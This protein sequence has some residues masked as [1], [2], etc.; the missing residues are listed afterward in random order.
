MFCEE[1]EE[2]FLIIENVLVACCMVINVIVTPF[3]KGLP[4][5]DLHKINLEK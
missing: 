3:L 5:V 4:I 1:I 2:I